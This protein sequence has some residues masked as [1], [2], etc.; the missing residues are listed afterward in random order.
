MSTAGRHSNKA[1]IR[2]YVENQKKIIKFYSKQDP[3]KLRV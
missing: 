3:G 2:K 1:K